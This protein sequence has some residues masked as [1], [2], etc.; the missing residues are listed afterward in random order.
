MRQVI[1]RTTGL[2]AV[3]VAGLTASGVSHAGAAVT[4]QQA[5]GYYRMMLGD[6]EITALSD[7]VV[8]LPVDKLLMN[9]SKA[10][11]TEVLAD[12]YLSAP[13]TTSVNSYLINTGDTLALVDA[14]AG[15]LF[16]PTLGKLV[17][18]LKAAGYAPSDVDEIYITHM[19]PDHLGGLVSGGEIVFPNAIV[20]AGQADAD[21]WLSQENLEAAPEG[22]K[23]FFKGAM[24]SVTPYIE[25]D[26]FETIDGRETLASGITALP[27]EGHTPGHHFFQVESQGETLKLWGDV[28]HVAPVQFPEPGVAIQFDSDPDDAVEVRQAEFRKASE[29]G[30]L[31]GSAHLSFPGLGR[32][33]DADAGYEFLPAPYEGDEYR[34]AE[35]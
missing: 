13:L 34:Q 27:A 5:P 26:Q 30:Y 24:A 16:G 18:N 25:A 11:V 22:D 9:T 28:I 2:A 12:H 32:L 7:G 8:S 20:H 14:G 21:Y 1:H 10:H 23:G 17:S 15:S 31:I 6:Y 3:L 4:G 19:H 35:E 33:R 29:Q